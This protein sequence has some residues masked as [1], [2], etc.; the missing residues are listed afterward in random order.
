MDTLSALAFITNCSSSPFTR[1]SPLPRLQTPPLSRRAPTV[2]V[3]KTS[4]HSG[5]ESVEEDVLQMFFKDREVNGDFISKAS[6]MLWQREV[7]KVVDPD[8]GQSADTGQQAEQVM[9]SDDDGGFLKLSRTQEWLL[10]D[11]SAPMNKKAIAKLKRELMLLSVGIGTACS[12]YCLIVLSVQAAVSYAVG[13]LFSCLYLQL[14]YQHVDNL[15]K[16]MVPPIFLLKKLK[17]IGI[18]SEDLQEFFERSIKGSG[19]ALSS[20]RLVIPAAV[21]G[22]WILS[23]K[24]LANDFFDFQLTPAMIGMFAYKAAALVQ[25]YRD[26]EDLQFV[27]PENE[28]QSSD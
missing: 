7:L 10:G 21:Y 25:V 1:F 19:I 3:L 18:R 14:L 13:V 16:E 6:D 20:P 26:N 23:H 15:S 9:G 27:F 17:K 28:E 2:F 12:G 5:S 4:S 8:A 22:L 24:F 11:N